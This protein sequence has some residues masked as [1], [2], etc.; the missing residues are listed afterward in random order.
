[1]CGRSEKMEPLI[2]LVEIKNPIDE[3]TFDFLLRYVEPYKRKNIQG[4][5]VKEEKDRMLV[6]DILVKYVLKTKYSIPMSN[7][8][9]QLGELGKPYLPDFP[10]IHFNISHSGNYV[11]CAFSESPVGIDI[12]TIMTYKEKIARRVLSPEKVRKIE[13]SNNPDLLFTRYW[14]EKEALLKIFACLLIFRKNTSAI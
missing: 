14:A 7:L 4:H 11:V 12:Q 1:M 8:N 10:H 9:I 3:L 2:Y 5:N 6:G 13:E